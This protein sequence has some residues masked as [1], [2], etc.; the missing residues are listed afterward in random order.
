MLTERISDLLASTVALPLDEAAPLLSYT[1]A[2]LRLAVR[3]GRIPGVKV[4]GRWMIPT[5]Y[6]RKVAAGAA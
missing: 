6:L 2:S 3:K 4:G 1:P 5:D